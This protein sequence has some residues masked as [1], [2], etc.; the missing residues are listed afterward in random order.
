VSAAGASRDQAVAGASVSGAPEPD[1]NP[2]KY[3]ISD[4]EMMKVLGKGTFG[5]VMLSKEKAT[6]EL[7]V[8]Q[9][10]TFW[11]VLRPNMPNPKTRRLLWSFRCLCFSVLIGAR[12]PD[13]CPNPLLFFWGK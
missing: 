13:V 3:T 1:L 12:N 6:G 10:W 2:K 8:R 5:K 11:P 9:T 4:F 7:Y